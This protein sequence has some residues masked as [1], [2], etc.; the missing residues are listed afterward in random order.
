V[1][2]SDPFAA[3]DAVAVAGGELTVARSGPLPRDADAVVLAVHGVTASHL[4]WRAIARELATTDD[5]VCLLAPDLRGRGHSAGLPGPYGI[6][7][8]VA[9]LLAVLDDAGVQRAVLAGHSM[10]GYV[11]ARLA[12]EHRERVA[13]VVLL[14]GGLPLPLPEGETPDTALEKVV[15]PAIARLGRTFASGA[16][17]VAQWRSHPALAAAWNDDVEAYAGYDMTG[18][19]GDVRCVVSEDA[20][21]ADSADLLD[22]SAARAAFDRIDAPVRLLRASRGFLDEEDK[23]FISADVLDAFAA[24]HPQVRVAQV[25]GVNHYTLMLGEG[26]GP[27]SVADSIRAALRE[28]DRRP[29]PLPAE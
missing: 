7:T 15:G 10:G 12:A 14:D 18:E 25:A 2:V 17:Y 27:L 4:A 8:H 22:E 13:A 6:A 5:G 24:E 16:E 20:V 23:P 9:D 19:A 28:D 21:R 1:P 3:L 26:P 29:H 11:V